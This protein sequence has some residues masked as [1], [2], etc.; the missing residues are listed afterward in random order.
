MT[1][2]MM[3]KVTG[4]TN[5][6]NDNNGRRFESP[7]PSPIDPVKAP[8]RVTEKSGSNR[9]LDRNEGNSKTR[10]KVV[11]LRRLLLAVVVLILVVLVV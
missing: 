6:I 7:P 5:A 8:C 1:T 4:I 11:A 3:Q 9:K 10:S 2:A